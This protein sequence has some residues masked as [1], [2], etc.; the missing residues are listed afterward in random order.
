MAIVKLN[1]EQINQANLANLI[2]L[3]QCYG[4]NQF[5]AVKQYQLT[6]NNDWPNRVW[7][8]KAQDAAHYPSEP[9]SHS[10]LSNLLSQLRPG[11]IFPTWPA[12]IIKALD[13]S[14]Q[15]TQQTINHYLSEHSKHWTLS[16]QQ[17]AM[18]LPLSDN[19]QLPTSKKTLYI[20]PIS[21]D[22]D[23]KHWVTVGSKAFGYQINY[24]VIQQLSLN[25]DIQL[26]LA[27]Q[28]Q[29]PVACGLLYQTG[30]IVGIHQVGI[31][32]EFQGQGLAKPLMIEMIKRGLDLGGDY[33]VLQ[34]SS[35]G[36]PLYQKL[37]FNE[38]FVIDNYQ[39]L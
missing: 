37:S 6:Q 23:I 17:T 16:F 18:Y 20:T 24:Q 26:L 3:W 36:K 7:F 27:W 11:S 1:K 4:A 8:D 15:A 9:I 34:A 35:A 30:K 28:D 25:S 2:A 39:K 12:N 31:V 19:L 5:N 29:I 38:Q 13:A 33:A 14:A 32:P 22:K 21:S 10:Q